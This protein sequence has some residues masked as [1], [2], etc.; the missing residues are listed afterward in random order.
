M[1]PHVL[2]VQSIDSDDEK[3]V[4]GWSA[5]IRLADYKKDCKRET[6]RAEEQK[7]IDRQ[8]DPLKAAE[9]DARATRTLFKPGKLDLTAK[10]MF[11]CRFR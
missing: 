4:Y 10:K 1:V 8:R 3:E 6:K 2:E 7:R 5:E 9:D 11:H